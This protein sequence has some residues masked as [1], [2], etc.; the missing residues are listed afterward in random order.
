[1]Y[2]STIAVPCISNHPNVKPNYYHKK[3][4]S[5]SNLSNTDETKNTQFE[6]TSSSTKGGVITENLYVIS[7]LFCS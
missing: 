5:Y 7:I 1:M 6:L 4:N 3:T 2:C